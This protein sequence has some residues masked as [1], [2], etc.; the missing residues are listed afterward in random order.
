MKANLTDHFSTSKVRYK[1]K[2]ISIIT[3]DSLMI[4]QFDFN[5]NNL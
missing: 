5:R 1:N 3:G 4:I 2:S